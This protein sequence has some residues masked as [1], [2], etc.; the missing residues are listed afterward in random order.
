MVGSALNGSCQC[1]VSRSATLL[2]AYVVALAAVGIMPDHLGHIRGM[3]DA[4]D[5]VKA[6]SPWVGPNVSCVLHFFQEYPD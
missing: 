4:Y 5:F 6:K 1:G 3:Q 2:I